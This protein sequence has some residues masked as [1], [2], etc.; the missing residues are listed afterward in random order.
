VSG[1]G[2]DECEKAGREG[3]VAYYRWGKANIGLIGCKEHVLEVIEALNKI[4]RQRVIVALEQLGKPKPPTKAPPSKAQL[5][6]LGLLDLVQQNEL[7][8]KRVK[9]DLL[10]HRDLWTAVWLFG[11][12]SEDLLPLRDIAE[13]HLSVDTLYIIPAEGKERELEALAKSWKADEVDWLDEEE[14]KRR[15][16]CP[17]E[18]LKV[19]RV[20]W[21]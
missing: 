3:R 17:N 15:M 16:G 12:E 19:L 13:D 5:A 1:V 14:C 20:W 7:N 6:I 11:G 18:G 8:G 2:C 10:K 4:Q 9:A 21:D